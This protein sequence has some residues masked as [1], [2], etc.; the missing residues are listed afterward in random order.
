LPRR[1]RIHHSKEAAQAAVKAFAD[2]YTINGRVRIDNTRFPAEQ[3][4]PL[5]DYAQDNIQLASG[6]FD[7][8]GMVGIDPKKDPGLFG[9]IA[10]SLTSDR[11]RNSYFA[12]NEMED[13]VVL[14]DEYE[15]AVTI[16]GKPVEIKFDD[17]I[18]ARNNFPALTGIQ[19]YS[20]DGGA[21]YRM[22]AQKD[23][24]L[25]LFGIKK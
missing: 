11:L 6:L 9:G 3:I 8:V 21:Q 15:Q 25:S 18:K 16:G 22:Q 24:V 4:T 13:G 1:L 19:A 5:L 2:Q 20:V 14:L 7:P 23:Y 10:Q 17:M 12:T